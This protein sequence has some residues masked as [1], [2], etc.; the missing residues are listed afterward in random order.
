MQVAKQH[1]D[2][3]ILFEHATDFVQV[4]RVYDGVQVQESGYR[5]TSTTRHAM[6]EA[7]CAREE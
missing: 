3:G 5:E 7:I 6:D 4:A 1:F 2:V